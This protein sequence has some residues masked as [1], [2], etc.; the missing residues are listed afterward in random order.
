MS[1]ITKNIA[2]CD[3]YRPDIL[4]TTLVS[5]E[6]RTSIYSHVHSIITYHNCH[7]ISIFVEGNTLCGKVI[8]QLQFD[9]IIQQDHHPV[10]QQIISPN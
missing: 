2:G 9:L 10:N 1:Y 5:R 3:C 8:P 4:D 7:N 6:E